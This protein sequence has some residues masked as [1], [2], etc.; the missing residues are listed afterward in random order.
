MITRKEKEIEFRENLIVD[1][2]EKLFGEKGFEKVTMEDIALEAEYTKPTLYNYFK[3]KE[4]IFFA[5]YLRGWY[6]STDLLFKA[7]ARKKTG[8][9]KLK[10]IAFVYNDYFKKHN[11]YFS[12]LKYIHNKGIKICDLGCKSEKEYEKVR[13]EKIE[14]FKKII[15]DGI[16]DGSISK[17]IEPEIA[18]MFFLNNLYINMHTYHNKKDVTDDFL[19]KATKLMLKVFK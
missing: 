1:A 10:A 9:N 11:I 6:N 17:G 12:L 16:K 13:K 19:E 5:V 15:A 3:N 8:F 2:A 4:E 14:D 7:A 18:V